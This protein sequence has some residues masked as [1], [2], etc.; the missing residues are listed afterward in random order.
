VVPLAQVL[1]NLGVK[2][3]LVVHG[4]DGFDEI[5]MS[6]PTSVCEV[7]HGDFLSYT[8]E[9]EAFGMK[10]YEKEALDGGSPSENAEITRAVLAG[11]KGARR[12]AVVL[13]SAAA[14]FIAKDGISMEEAIGIAEETIDSG[15][16]AKQLKRYVALSCAPAS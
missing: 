9:P 7:R 8:I 12:D 15:K 11:E 13:N 14:I 4:Q 3:A 16:A 1:S 10:R 5:S 6:A 2:R